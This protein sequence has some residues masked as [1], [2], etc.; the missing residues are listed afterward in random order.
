[1]LTTEWVKQKLPKRLKD[2]IITAKINR[3][4]NVLTFTTNTST[5]LRIFL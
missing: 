2:Q 4:S 5:I 1:M 3:Q